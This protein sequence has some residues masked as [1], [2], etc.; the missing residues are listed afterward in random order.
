MVITLESLNAACARF[1]D[2]FPALE[3]AISMQTNL[4]QHARCGASD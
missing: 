4:E 2:Y 1:A 3:R